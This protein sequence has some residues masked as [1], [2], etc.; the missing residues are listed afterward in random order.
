MS[1]MH[2]AADVAERLKCSK[3][4]VREQGLAIGVGVAL[5]GRAGYRYSD[6]DV[7]RLLESMRPAAPV[8][9]R[10]RRRRTT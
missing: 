8:E 9:A 1:T 7:D 3:R 10:R 6:Q 5:G 4:K 2:T